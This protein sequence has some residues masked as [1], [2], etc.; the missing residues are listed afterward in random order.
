M[1]GSREAFAWCTRH[2]H[3]LQQP[4]FFLLRDVVMDYK[5]PNDDSLLEEF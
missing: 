5:A 4:F 2:H 1:L 3:H